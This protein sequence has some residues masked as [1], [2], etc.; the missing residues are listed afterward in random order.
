M[1]QDGNSLSRRRF[2]SAAGTATAT[3]ALAGCTG[4]NGDETTTEETSGGGETTTEDNSGGNGGSPSVLRYGRGS[5]SPTLDFQ[6]DTSGEVAKVTE[7]MY[8]TLINFEPGKSTLTQGLATEYT[9]E[10]K[11]ASI[12]LREGVK[13]HNGEEF[14]AAD[15][16]AT[17]RRFVDNSYENYAGDDYVSA[18]GPFTLGSW[19]DEIQ[20]DGDYSMTIKLTQ[21]YA[22]FLRN[23][24]MFAA[25]VH[26]K[27]A[28]E[29]YGTELKKNPV[30]TGPFKLSN[31]DDAN[32]IIRLEANTDYW[33][34]GPNVDE[35]VFVTIGQNSTRAQSLASGELDIV[36]G[37]GAQ[38]SVQ[39]ENASN[40]DLVRTEGINI[41]YMAF[42]MASVEEFRDKRVR[43]AISHA[44]NTE[45]IVNEIYSGFAT[46][47]SQPLPPNVLGHN[48]DLDPYPYDTD[49]AQSLLEEA[50]Y[51]DGFSFELATFQNPRGYN[52]SPIQTAETVASNLGEIGID[53]EIN[54]QSFSPFLEYTA[55]GRHDACF[56][57][58]YTDNADPDNFMY[59]LLHPQVEEGELTEGQDWV[60]FDAEGY[61]TSNR[62][63]WANSEYMDLIEQGQS[64]YD[65]AE[66]ESLYNQ[67]NQIAHDEA[68]WVYLDYADELRGVSK[69]VSGF[70]IAAISGPYLNLVSL[71]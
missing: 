45:A 67:A 33:G 7:Q 59:V 25:A 66:R 13:F 15:F 16:V 1:S 28:I 6:N 49:K 32:E 20:V 68:P 17:Y 27:A 62:S 48:D 41:G 8:D 53:V 2:L 30:G 19:I 37:L 9:L 36:D 51:G 22:P 29:E 24:A 60:S 46:Q 18:Y 31:L 4:G 40:A 54:Q 38:S 69:R 70:K 57:G 47:A 44:I 26:S 43:Q 5:H 58:W 64:T 50:G 39:V 23:L 14:T 34:E 63:G 11:T 21:T 10:G 55:Q 65:E 71:N 3:A 42:N 61:N 56:L 35:V 12:T 52:P